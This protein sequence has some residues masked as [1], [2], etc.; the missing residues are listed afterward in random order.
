MLDAW[1]HA[2]DALRRLL[3]DRAALA[4]LPTPVHRLPG[5]SRTAGREIWI[6]RDDLTGVGLG[7]NKV[8]KLEL[9]LADA[10]S[11]HADVLVSVG[12]PQ[13]NHARTVAAAAS[14]AGLDC[15]LVLAG[16]AP[17]LA[18]GNLHLD[19]LLG[20]HLHFAGT[21]DWDALARATHELADRLRA[22]G[23]MPYVIPVGGSVAHGVAAF[24]AAW[25]ELRD[26]TAQLGVDFGAVIHA[27]SSGGTQAGLELGRM[28]TG[29]PEVIGVDVAKITSPL[30][31]EVA[32]LMEETG[33]LLGIEVTHPSPNVLDGY[34]GEGYAVS[35]QASR[36]ALESLARLDGIIADPVYT[37]K[38]LDA[39]LT[40]TDLPAGPLLFWHTGGVPAL[41][42]EPSGL[43]ATGADSPGVTIDP[44]GVPVD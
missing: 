20:A 30:S 42:A 34:L 17:E 8:R 38:A 37:A 2:P 23:R 13:S 15:E 40:S 21:D 24:T 31:A 25:Y 19:V 41:F 43:P 36:A 28:L 29:G 7:G 12:A 27:S 39:L 33:G 4:V 10:R 18:T 1:E 14:I 6:K 35:S 3:R 16:T 5:L 9:I 11:R 22:D 26:Q 32:R 44:L